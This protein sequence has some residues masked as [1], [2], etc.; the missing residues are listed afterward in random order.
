MIATFNQLT[1]NEEDN[2]IVLKELY[3]AITQKIERLKER[4][5]E[6]KLSANLYKKYSDKYRHEKKEIETELFWRFLII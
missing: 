4:S 5:I 6:E 2:S 3:T 1:K